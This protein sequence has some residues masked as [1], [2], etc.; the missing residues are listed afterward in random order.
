MVVPAYNEERGITGTVT[1]LRD[2]LQA[3]D[4][5]P[6]EVLVVDNASARRHRRRGAAAWSTA[7]ASSSC[8]TSATAARATRCA[9]ACSPPAASCACTATPTARPRSSSLPTMLALLEDADVVVGSRLAPGARLGQRQPLPRRIVGRSFVLLCRAVLSEPTTD[10]YCGF[11]L[12][13]GPVAE[14]VFARIHLDGWTFDAEALAMARALGYRLRETGIVWTDRE[15]SRLSMARVLVPVVRELIAA[16]RHS[17]ARRGAPPPRSPRRPR[18]SPRGSSCP[19]PS[20][21]ARQRG[22]GDGWGWTGS[23]SP[24]CSR[25]ARWPSACSSACSCACGSRAAWSPA[26]T[27]TWSS[28]RSST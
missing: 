25:C 13:R 12:W 9:G 18:R 4:P 3:R 26:P 28:T 22:R 11:K 15:G 6:F 5:R 14:D 23:S 27:A 8:A 24:P 20:Q 19:R 17:A 7:S 16:R 10:L 1:A 21:P 2:W